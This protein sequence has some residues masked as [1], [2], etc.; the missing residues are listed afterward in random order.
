LEE[1]A[2]PAGADAV[3]GDQRGGYLYSYEDL[4]RIGWAA[5]NGDDPEISTPRPGCNTSQPYPSP[6]SAPVLAT[7]SV[8]CG[9]GDTDRRS[10]VYGLED[11]RRT[12][13]QVAG[14]G[15][16]LG[17]YSPDGTNLAY[18]RPTSAPAG[19]P[20]ATEIVDVATAER[21][22]SLDGA[23]FPVWYAPQTA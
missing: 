1:L 16:F 6:E 11:D 9:D 21:L 3:I 12:W 8:S 10:G 7:V 2:V 20:Y 15:A 23:L 22:D 14:H 4:T 18:C 17:T 5:R 19:L 13:R